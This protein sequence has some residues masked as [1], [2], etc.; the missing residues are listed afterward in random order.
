MVQKI[1]KTCWKNLETGPRTLTGFNAPIRV[2]N[3][4]VPPTPV[5]VANELEASLEAR[6]KKLDE[7]K[8]EQRRKPRAPQVQKLI[9]NY[10]LYI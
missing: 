5:E 10:I 3:Y 8:A 2:S 6:K 4:E 9:I 1:T 7:L